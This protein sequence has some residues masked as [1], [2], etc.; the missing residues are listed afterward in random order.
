MPSIPNIDRGT[1]KPIE[2]KRKNSFNL[3]FDDLP[4]EFICNP[5]KWKEDQKNQPKKRRRK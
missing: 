4:I 1:E 5:S 3:I 2:T